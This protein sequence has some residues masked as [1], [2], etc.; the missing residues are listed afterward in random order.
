MNIA[1]GTY[2]EDL[3]R[4]ESLEDADSVIRLAKRYNLEIGEVVDGQLVLPES[5]LG[6]HEYIDLEIRF[7][8][9][10]LHLCLD[11]PE[12]WSPTYISKNMY[13]NYK[14]IRQI[15][16]VDGG[17]LW[18]R[19]K[20]IVSE[21]Y[22]ERFNYRGPGRNSDIFDKY[23]EERDFYIECKENLMLRRIRQFIEENY[24]IDEDGDIR[25]VIDPSKKVSKIN[26]T[27]FV[28]GC[29]LSSTVEMLH[30]A[31]P[32]FSWYKLFEKL[33][34]PWSACIQ[35]ACR[36]LYDYG[37]KLRN[38]M[39]KISQDTWDVRWLAANYGSMRV[40]IARLNDE[41]EW[42]HFLLEIPQDVFERYSFET[43]GYK[44]KPKI[45]P[46]YAARKIMILLGERKNWILQDLDEELQ[47]LVR[48]IGVDS[49]EKALGEGYRY[50]DPDY[51]VDRCLSSLV[52]DVFSVEKILMKHNY[53]ESR[54]VAKYVIFKDLR[55]EIFKG[56]K[57]AVSKIAEILRRMFKASGICSDHQNFSD[58]DLAKSVFYMSSS[59]TWPQELN[60]YLDSIGLSI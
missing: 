10:I 5:V 33:P 47:D 37:I 41:R 31:D 56:N 9:L 58:E 53:S 49:V 60:S 14:K 19:L 57:E 50:V 43:E 4:L 24:L 28:R 59:N 25:S 20:G 52:S 29:D 22:L 23:S 35:S 34:L 46:Y 38:E 55:D 8:Q 2:I 15:F 36:G 48:E 45:A 13:G 16:S 12:E 1:K 7:M 11:D 17:M 51:V 39:H 42:G 27:V 32:D 26:S 30:D 6:D 40:S 54:R 21:K 3:G 44:T 18:S